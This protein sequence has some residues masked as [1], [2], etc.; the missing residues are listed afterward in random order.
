MGLKNSAYFY[1]QW[2]WGNNWEPGTRAQGTP[3]PEHPVF[4]GIH[5]FSNIITNVV[6]IKHK[7]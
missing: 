5:N 7:N 4:M 3:A 6:D 2:C 1:F